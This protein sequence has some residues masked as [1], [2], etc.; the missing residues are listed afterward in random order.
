[1]NVLGISGLHN[2]V[3]FK[4]KVF[5]SLSDREYQIA[6]GLDSAAAIVTNRGVRA[7]AA[8]ERF[9]GEK[10]TGAFPT[11]AIAYCLATANLAPQDVDYV[12][13]GFSYE[14]ARALYE[15]SRFVHPSQFSEVFSKD[16]QIRCIQQHLPSHD[17]SKKLVQVPHHLAHAASAFYLSG[18]DEALIWIADG[19]GETESA[20][21]AVGSG[22]D[23]NIVER[24]PALHSLGVLYGT[25]TLYLGFAM[26]ADEYK[27]MG[28]APYGNRSR[29]LG[30]IM[31]FI[32]LYD[33]G[34]YTIPLLSYDRT[35]E[36]RE[37]HRGVIRK[38]SELFGP[39]RMP[40]ET[41]A[42]IHMDIAAAVQAAVEV[43]TMHVLRHFRQKTG[44]QNLCMAGGVSLNCTANAAILESGMFH[45]MFVQPAA[46]DDGSSLGAALY[47]QRQNEPGF[48]YSRAT[49]PLWG[50][51]YDDESIL[52]SIRER[53]D[54]EFRRFEC[55]DGLAQNVAERL[56]KGQVIG[57]FQG[58]MEFGPRAL[59]NRS[60]LAD[61]RFPGMRDHINRLVK[62][63]EAFRPFAPA[64]VA[65]EASRFFEVDVGSESTYSSMLFLAKVRKEFRSR[66]P[67]VTHGDGSAR[68][69]TVDKIEHPQFWHLIAEFGRVSGIPV[70]LN[71]SLNV[72]GQPIVCTPDEALSTFFSA[73]LDALAMGR[74]L[75]FRTSP[76]P[77]SGARD[78]RNA[79]SS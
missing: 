37:T 58:R 38:L 44:I 43:C 3:S 46:G 29:F 23:I 4:R 14:P 49:L 35:I 42:Q 75:I 60:I 59:G 21:V 65:E 11:G 15:N 39:P 72:R 27:V 61:P 57:W 5:P 32:R 50:P 54:C 45:G 77:A 26:G 31:D 51:Q 16:A 19:M 55:Y 78:S 67:A 79:E 34:T 13:H 53:G 9:S 6:Q 66:L 8:E 69:Q 76:Q 22:P 62:K 24:I 7:A 56:S 41:I 64:V 17:W 74:Y 10:H 73:N 71:T 63:R 40:S 28:L 68:V 33:D 2:S 25:F 18:F 30:A 36:E 70:L 48:R 47:V 12:A 1:M 20:T 52:H